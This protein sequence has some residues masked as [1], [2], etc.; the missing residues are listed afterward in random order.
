MGWKVIVAPDDERP[1]S[2]VRP[3]NGWAEFLDAYST[4]PRDPSIY[5]S[6]CAACHKPILSTRG[7]VQGR[8][9]WH[10]GCT[11]LVGYP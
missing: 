7:I 9:R 11:R 5:G 4:R 3:S 6:I 10:V 1:A 2:A 8:L